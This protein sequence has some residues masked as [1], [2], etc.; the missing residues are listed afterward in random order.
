MKD[1]YTFQNVKIEADQHIL[2]FCTKGDRRRIPVEEIAGLHLLSGYEITS[3]AILLASEHHF[4]IHIYSF[5]GMYKGTFFPEPLNKAG[6]MLIKQVESHT[7]EEIRMKHARTIVATARENMQCLMEFLGLEVEFIDL[8]A[9]NYEGLLLEEARIRKEYYAQLD[10]VL[11][12]YWSIVERRRRPPKRPADAVL[13]FCNGILYAKM[14]GF[15]HRAGL[16]PRIGYIHGD[17]RASNPLSLD[18]AEI[19]KPALSEQVLLEIGGSGAERSL[20][21]HV[22]EGCYLN[23]KGRKTV[24]KL[25]EDIGGR[26]IK[27]SNPKKQ[28]DTVMHQVEIIP[29]KLH[30]SLV[31][32]ETPSYPVIP[33]TLSSRTMQTLNSGRTSVEL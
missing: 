26:T 30:R 4:P 2:R 33:C 15:I 22:E 9:D 25:I 27:L 21:T 3:G 20:I 13:G 24:I 29:K 7:D 31:C 19:G 32:G 10:A 17:T 1:Y 5:Y 18:L 14:S 28:Y 12:A 23:E 11:P 6:V 16:D 8:K